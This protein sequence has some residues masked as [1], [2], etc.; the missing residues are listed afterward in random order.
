MNEI[1]ST[2]LFAATRDVLS[3]NGTCSLEQWIKIRE[4][5]IWFEQVGCS[6]RGFYIRSFMVELR[7]PRTDHK[8][9]TR[10]TTTP[11]ESVGPVRGG[12]TRLHYCSY[13]N[14]MV[15]PTQTSEERLEKS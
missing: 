2:L 8:Q 13:V 3:V 15:L 10:W 7:I 5:L 1:L 12:R 14:D 9:V 11:K 6:Y 4:S